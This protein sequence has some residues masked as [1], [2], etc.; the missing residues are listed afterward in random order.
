MGG[1]MAA[2]WR[3]RSYAVGSTRFPRAVRLEASA[4][5][6]QRYS[7]GQ[8]REFAPNWALCFAPTTLSDI[9]TI[10]F[11]REHPFCIWPW[12]TMSTSQHSASPPNGKSEPSPQVSATSQAEVNPSLVLCDPQLESKLHKFLRKAISWYYRGQPI[13]PG[14]Q[15]LSILSFYL[16]P[17]DQPMLRRRVV[18]AIFLMISAK[19]I[20]IQV[21]PPP[22]H[23]QARART[24]SNPA[25]T[26]RF[27]WGW[28]GERARGPH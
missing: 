5:P 25:P 13:P 23:T 20:N 18:A 2:A 28:L 11:G 24:Q 10:R 4:Q 3:R 1:S 17:K 16:W 15:V 27:A 26:P 21:S 6:N 7:Q 8:A 19:M 12:R 9:R 14:A 22:N